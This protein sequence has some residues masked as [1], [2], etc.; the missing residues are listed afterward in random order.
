M[1]S[2]L[3]I[4]APQK[5]L[6]WGMTHEAVSPVLK[7]KTI[8]EIKEI[9][10][11]ANETKSKIAFRGGGCSYG[12]ASL[13][14]DGILVDMSDYNKIIEWDDSKGVLKAEAGVTIQ[15]MWEFAIEKGYWPPVVSGT[16]FPTLGG[17]LAMNIHGKNN[18]GVGP[19]GDHVLE[20]T[21]LTPK[22]EIL[23]CNRSENKDLFYTAISGLGMLG[24]FLE[25]TIKMKKIYSGKLI[26]TPKPVKNLEEMIQYFNENLDTS[27]YLVGWVDSF[28][29]GAGLGRGLIHKA[30][31]IPEGEDPNFKEDIKLKN[32]HLPS[33]LFGVIPKSW[34]WLFMF[35][36][37]NK[38]GMRLVNYVKYLT[39]FISTKKYKQGHAAFAFLLDYVPNWKFV[40][41]PG[42]M[43]QYQTFIPK[44]NA[45]K[46][47]RE[48]FELCHKRGKPPFLAVFKKHRKDDFL[49]THS[50]DGFS[51]AMDFPVSKSS[52]KA[53][54][55]LCYEIDEL[56]I[57]YGGRF[58]FAKDSTLRK[59]VAEKV[60][61]KETIDK[62]LKLKEKL[63]PN[64]ILQSDLFK[65]IFLS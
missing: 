59:V 58:Y 54:W 64:Q 36:F 11:Y 12:D 35:P 53:L 29:G 7:P 3:K 2:N 21:F 43:I 1:A 32:Q 38:L 62:Y 14:S 56:V 34:M 31:Y 25:I 46:A 45:L 60:F 33:T 26:V 48:I 39:G 40:Y 65:R 9:F 51:M 8:E 28:A 10:S 61:S 57:K 16:M 24:C 44:E 22:G 17:A 4:P 27:D 42:S 30:D 18:F 23:K 55:D 15:Q 50:V 47:Y 13:N 20:F 6:S 37:S 41:K 63:D 52:K 19:I 5:V 49:L